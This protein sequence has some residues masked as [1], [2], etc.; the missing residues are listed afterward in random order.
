MP[1]QSSSPPSAVRPWTFP[2]AVWKQVKTILDRDDPP[3][4]TGRPR[5]DRRRILEGIV[6]RFSQ[7]CRWRQLPKA[8]G[9]D[10]TVHR[11]FQRWDRLGIFE[12][13]WSVLVQWRPELRDVVWKWE[14]PTSVLRRENSG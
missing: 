7:G 1:P 11:A 6:F 5:K 8:F 9:D 10:S 13:V 2:D 14:P 12:R 4:H 3:K